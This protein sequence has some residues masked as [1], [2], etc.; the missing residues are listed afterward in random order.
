MRRLATTTLAT[1]LAAVIA[2]A[3]AAAR[4]Q[5][6]RPFV[7]TP[8]SRAFDWWV[9]R[10][11]EVVDGKPDT[12]GGAF[13]VTRGPNGAAFEETWRFGRDAGS[14]GS[15][16]MRAW[17]QW[18]NR[19]M[20]AWVAENALFQV[21]EGRKFGDTWYIV[22]PFEVDGQRWV[23][24]QAWI[25]TGPDRMVHVSERSMD[26]ERTWQPRFRREFARVP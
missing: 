16:A 17:D 24:R 12:T 23:T 1:T 8:D 10:W 14:R 19:W 3:P 6:D 4:A 9:G 18:T 20:F 26:G 7:P 2:L 13:L 25:P 22:R 15:R 21:W 11:F 5:T